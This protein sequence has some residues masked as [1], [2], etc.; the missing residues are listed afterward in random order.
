MNITE[1]NTSKANKRRLLLIAG[2]LIT[3]IIAGYFYFTSGRYVSTENAF[4]KSDKVIISPEVA[5]PVS[6]LL[7]SENQAVKKG[8]VLFRIGSGSYTAAFQRAQANL[9]KTRSDILALQAAY[10]AKQ[11]E[12]ILSRNNLAFAEKEYA[13]QVDLFGKGFT[14]QVQLDDRKHLLDVSRQQVI[15]LEQDA[16]RVLASLDNRANAPVE[17]HPS[18]LA[19]QADLAQARINLEHTELHAPF[20]GIATNLPK[21]GQH[22]NAGGPA[23]SVVADKDIWIEANFNETDMTRVLV[24]QKVAIRVDTYPKNRW[25]GTVESLSP[26]TGA[27]FSILPAQNASGNWV[28]VIQRIPVRIRIEQKP[29]DP[30]LRAGMSAHVEI[31]TKA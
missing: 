31:D 7:V 1:A 12:L 24:G 29:D 20:D 30:V 6:E 11:A 13:R 10:K 8:D 17:Q 2:P 27:E 22:V 14:S 9:E 25:Q 15:M 26:A 21:L 19:A 16:A 23:M 5:G 28:K 3:A 4:L 18:Y